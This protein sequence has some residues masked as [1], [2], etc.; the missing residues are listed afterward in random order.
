MFE[1]DPRDPLWGKPNVVEKLPFLPAI[2]K[3]NLVT[4]RDEAGAFVPLLYHNQGSYYSQVARLALIESGLQFRYRDIDLHK[5][6]AEQNQEWYL[7]MHPGGVVP[8]LLAPPQI[9]S[10]KYLPLPG[11]EP[12]L[13]FIMSDPWVIVR[14]AGYKPS[15]PHEIFCMSS[16]AIPEILED[17]GESFLK[18]FF[19]LDIEELS[20]PWMAMQIPR[21][22]RFVTPHY[23]MCCESEKHLTGTAVKTDSQIVREA[24]TKKTQGNKARLARYLDPEEA[25]KHGTAEALTFLSKLDTQLERSGGPFIA[26]PMYSACD[27]VA[28]VFL[29]RADFFPLL[30]D[31]IRS[32]PRVAEYDHLMQERPSYKAAG[33]LRSPPV[34]P[35]AIM[36]AMVLKCLAGKA[37]KSARSPL[38]MSILVAF[39]GAAVAFAWKKF[40]N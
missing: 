1:E 24:C 40:R 30:R 14:P 29:A 20:I 25:I 2:S 18:S 21:F 38:G 26:G 28:T 15:S 27:V 32:S 3:P 13:R 16:L 6:D 11:S 19:S 10:K 37:F 36:A 33:V 9:R 34:S 23:E 4:T 5:A 17:D 8:L 35:K 7:R 39:V 12:T 22:L 31:A